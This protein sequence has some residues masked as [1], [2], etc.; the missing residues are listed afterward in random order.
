MVALLCI[1]STVALEVAVS[2]PLAVLFFDL[3]SVQ[4]FPAFEDSLLILLKAAT[5]VKSD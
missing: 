4:C 1:S 3:L 5:S 2:T